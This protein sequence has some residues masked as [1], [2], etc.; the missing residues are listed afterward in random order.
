MY[1]NLEKQRKTPGRALGEPGE[2]WDG[3]GWREEGSGGELAAFLGHKQDQG[4]GWVFEEETVSG[5][6]LHGVLQGCVCPGDK[7]LCWKGGTWPLLP[8]FL[9]GVWAG[10]DV[11]KKRLRRAGVGWGCL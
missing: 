5:P 8:L 10:P 6:E 1:G 4:V 11:R 7:E 9:A 3:Q 2:V